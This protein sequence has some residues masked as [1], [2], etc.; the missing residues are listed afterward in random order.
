[1]SVDMAWQDFVKTGSSADQNIRQEIVESWVRCREKGI[2][3][4]KP[5]GSM[6]IS[7]Q[8][9]EEK[10]SLKQELL[11]S[12]KP[13][14]EG[15]FSVISDSEYF[16]I[17]AD[18]NGF[19][20]EV[21]GEYDTLIA[22]SH[23]D[24]VPGANWNEEIKGT[25]AISACLSLRSPVQVAGAEHY[26]KALH[27]FSASAAPV[28]NSD[29]SVRGVLVIGAYDNPVPH[30]H[31]LGTAIVAAKSVEHR[32]ALERQNLVLNVVNHHLLESCP[33]AIISVDSMGIVTS[34]NKGAEDLCGIPSY[35]ALGENVDLIFASEKTGTGNMA[36]LLK[37]TLKTGRPLKDLNYTFKLQGGR[38]LTCMV[39]S[40]PLNNIS[41]ELIGVM[42]VLRKQATRK[43]PARNDSVFL[44]HSNS[45]AIIDSLTGLFNH[46][47]FHERLEEE[48]DRAKLQNTKLSL[49]M[50]D[51]DYFK[52]YNEVL[53]YPAGDKLLREFAE[54]LKG[55]VRSKDVISRYGGE[56]FAIILTD[57]DTKLALDVAERICSCVE[58]H[59]F[60]GREVQPKGKLTVSL[61][62]ATFPDNSVNREELLKMSEEA[63]YRAKH[64][65]KSKVALYFSVFD[66][67]KAE[68]NHSDFNLLNTIKT[69]ITVI[70]AKDKYTFG[71]S[72]RVLK[73]STALAGHLGLDEEQVK[74]I[75][76]GAYLHD[77]G[78]IEISREILN[79][80][81][82]L[83]DDEWLVLK[84]HPQWGADIIKPV[85]ALQQILPQ[86]L[87]HHE[88]FDGKGYPVGLGGTDIPLNARILAIADSF[89]AMTTDR[90][91]KRGLT[92]KT[93]VKELYRCS[94]AQFDPN[95]VELFVK[96]LNKME[97]GNH[98]LVS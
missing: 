26:L 33:H 52:H 1:M 92:L 63:L 25:N 3:P 67:L 28:L 14:V 60:D 10:C 93:A 44:R 76:Y 16:I 42:A 53:G 90:P 65:S 55:L 35:S 78:K 94:G 50:L 95:L 27:S 88:R 85:S 56:E 29:G 83:T 59:P 71:H 32:L 37:S 19:I 12:V 43:Q 41:G 49:L 21:S 13:F 69:L 89:D 45:P 38:S 8:E 82:T 91:Y 7:Q 36:N 9:L 18:E 62:V 22:A 6:H 66:D 39:D 70:N 75:K 46:K 47:Y 81:G 4:L 20:L 86:I 77:I 74:F 11:S 87:Y 79:K 58:N 68:L 30:P 23:I 64:I 34:F 17:L 54:I 15:L 24:I 84:C 80:K 97:L 40:H 2:N 31:T 61:G 5:A 48:V 72:E 57:T 98:V 96:A 73:Y 51:I